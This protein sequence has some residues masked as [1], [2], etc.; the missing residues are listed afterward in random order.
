MKEGPSHTHTL[1]YVCGARPGAREP[2]GVLRSMPLVSV[3]ARSLHFHV[4][5]HFLCAVVFPNVRRV[6]C[7]AQ[8]KQ[9]ALTNAWTV[10]CPACPLVGVPV[11]APPPFA[12]CCPFSLFVGCLGVFVCLMFHVHVRRTR[13]SRLIS[14][15]PFPTPPEHV[16]QHAVKDKDKESRLA[17]TAAVYAVCGVRCVCSSR[18][19]A[20]C[21]CV[22]K[23]PS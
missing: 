10:A 1:T 11:P 18:A 5:L 23:G 19:C 22:A 7:F 13:V 9:A 3:L 17:A 21:V 14:S 15:L 2:I 16:T 8:Q 12:L 6:L 20:I 4:S